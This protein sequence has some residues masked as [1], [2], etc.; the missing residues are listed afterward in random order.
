VQQP[1]RLENRFRDRV[2][3]GLL[4]SSTGMRTKNAISIKRL[5]D[6]FAHLPPAIHNCFYTLPD[7]KLSRW[8]GP[9][10]SVRAPDRRAIDNP[11]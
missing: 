7:A 2:W 5:S 4:E 1:H 9:P 8:K 10:Q 3:R 6:Q 11:P